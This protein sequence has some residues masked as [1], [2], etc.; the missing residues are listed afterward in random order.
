M[1]TI[2]FLGRRG[3][4]YY[5]QFK[6]IDPVEID[7]SIYIVP[8]G[9][10][11]PTV[12]GE[13]H[14]RQCVSYFVG[15]DAWA[16]DELWKR[17]RDWVPFD[18]LV[19][20]TDSATLFDCN[21]YVLE[22]VAYVLQEGVTGDAADSCNAVSYDDVGQFLFHALGRPESLPQVS[23]V[24]LYRQ[25]RLLNHGSK[26]LIEWLA[27]VPPSPRRIDA[28]F[29]QYWSLLHAT[30]LLERIVG[31]P[32]TCPQSAEQCGV[33]GQKPQP[34]NALSRR[35]W[36]RQQLQEQMEDSTLVENAAQ[37]VEAALRVRNH[38]SH[39]PCFNRSEV[40]QMESHMQK[41]EYDAARAAGEFK[42]D[43]FAL[44]ALRVALHHLA[45]E[46]L[47]DKLFGLK[48]F[49]EPRSLKFVHLTESGRV[50]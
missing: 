2:D 20:W 26:E 47:V 48:H 6:P 21:A 12:N 14:R 36:L 17:F 5:S 10:C 32:P 23:Y 38:M 13:N 22:P 44:L 39:S 30:I 41:F 24:H 49:T 16:D 29:G 46:L 15:P 19:M 4:R 33:C 34:H 35:V 7:P 3:I 9:W 31:R 8:A 45:H 27:S 1:K 18:G 11:F 50:G 28:F 42:K 25:Y 40:P 43:S 37:L